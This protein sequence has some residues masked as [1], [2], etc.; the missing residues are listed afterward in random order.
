MAVIDEGNVKF[1]EL[2]ELFVQRKVVERNKKKAELE[3]FEQANNVLNKI[4]DELGVCITHLGES[5][6][7][8]IKGIVCEVQEFNNAKGNI[9]LYKEELSSEKSALSGNTNVITTKIK[10]LNETISSLNGEIYWLY[11][12]Q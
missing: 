5:Y 1:K 12:G 4:I 6:D 2:Q 8:L 7:S 10:E 3:K 11:K 9:E